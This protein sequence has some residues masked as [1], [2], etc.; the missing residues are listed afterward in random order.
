MTHPTPTQEDEEDTQETKTT[1][2]SCHFKRT[3]LLGILHKSESQAFQEWEDV[4]GTPYTVHSFKLHTNYFLIYLLP[5]FF[6]FCLELVFLI[7][8]YKTSRLYSLLLLP[9][10]APS[11]PL[12]TPHS[13]FSLCHCKHRSPVASLSCH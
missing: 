9:S 4:S 6:L 3:E 1:R 2:L 12:I 10:F 11:T 8:F 5:A 13:S 7:W